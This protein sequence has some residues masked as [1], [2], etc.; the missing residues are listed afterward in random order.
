[1]VW[2]KI[3]SIRPLPLNHLHWLKKHYNA[4]ILSLRF[5]GR[6]KAQ[7][8]ASSKMIY[9]VQPMVSTKVQT[10]MLIL[11]NIWSN[12]KQLTHPCQLRHTL[13]S[14]LVLYCD[15]SAVAHSNIFNTV[16]AIAK[17]N[18]PYLDQ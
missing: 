6:Q 3:R 5:L 12:L 11:W 2:R 8:T 15:I 16:V 14:L 9:L 7:I 10:A 18:C 1:M 4:I 17:T 13:L